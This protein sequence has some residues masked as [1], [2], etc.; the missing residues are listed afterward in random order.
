MIDFMLYRFRIGTFSNNKQKRNKSNYAG[1]CIPNLGSFNHFLYFAYIFI[2]IYIMSVTMAMLVD[3]NTMTFVIQIPR[4]TKFEQLHIFSSNVKLFAVLLS[5]FL[6]KRTI[7]GAAGGLDLLGICRYYHNYMSKKHYLFKKFLKSCEYVYIWIYALNFLLI[8]IINPSL[9]NPGPSNLSV[10]FQNLQGLIP[11]SQLGCTHPTL[12]STKIFEINS[13]LNN[14][15]P[16]IFIWN[17]TWLKRS[18]DDNEVVNTDKYKIFRLDR[19]N[20]T[21][22]PDPTSSRKFRSNG[23]G[24]MIGI[25]RELDVISAGINISCKAEILGVTLKFRNGKKVAIC[26]C[27]RVGTLGVANHNNIESYI[28][29]VL[30]R[31]GINN[32]VLIG[33]F[34]MAHTQWS[35]YQTNDNVERLFLDS[36][37]NFG[38]QQLVDS[39]THCKGNIL[40]L[41]LTNSPQLVSNI[42]VADEFL[43]CKSDHFPIQFKVKSYARKKKTAK[44]EIYN[45]KRANW[46]ALISELDS[47]NW[48]HLLSSSDVEVAWNAFK[49]HLFCVVDKH[50]PKIKIQNQFQPPW[51]DSETYELCREKE[52]LRSA[53]KRTKSDVNYVK[54]ANCRR[55]FKRLVQGK[56]RDNFKD[57]YNSNLITKKFWSYVKSK[58][59]SHRIPDLV[60][61]KD[62]YR[63]N[64]IDQAELFNKFF[65]DQFSEPSTYD[66]EIDQTNDIFNIDFRCTRIYNILH[67]LNVNKA[68]GPDGIHGKVLKHCAT[69]ISYPL[70][71]LFNLSYTTGKIP[72]EWKLANVVPVHKKGCKSNVE[73]YRPISL[74][75][76]V[77]KV[78]EKVI[79]DELMFRCGHL[80]D[81]RQHGFL[82]FRS[83]TT[84]MIG[85]CDS[86]ALSLNKNTRSDVIY[87]DF[88][89]AFDTV[90]H[91]LILRKLKFQYNI[92][93]KLLRFFINYLKNRKQCIVLSNTKSSVQPVISGV[94]QGSILGPT[95]F[96]LFLNDITSGLNDGTNICMYADDTKVWREINCEND[97]LILQNDI[98]YLLD[99]AHNNKMKFHPSK[100]KVLS[101]TRN[102]PPLLDILPNIQF[103]Y[104]LGS[105]IID[106]CDSEKDLGI[107]M[108]GSLNFNEHCEYLYSKANQK[109]AMLKRN[110]NFVNNARMKR[111]LYLTLVRSIFEHCPIVW[112][113]ASSSPVDKLESIQKRAFKWIFDDLTSSY[114]CMELYYAHCKQLNILP[115]KFRFDYHD[116]KMFHIIVNEYICVK[117]PAY[118]KPFSENRLRSSHLDYKC[119]VSDISPRNL[120]SYQ[121]SSTNRSNSAF[122][123]SFFY[124]THL[125]WNRLPLSL[126]ETTNINHFKSELKAHIWREFVSNNNS[127][128]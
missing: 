38:F 94:P 85:Y 93:G 122:G 33:D 106:Y 3:L 18:I 61:L 81:D 90:N 62:T 41:L 110:C 43:M 49:A 70:S 127:I 109:L 86:L 69:S 39:P 114:S 20:H 13:Y 101:I 21:H 7:V 120:N 64:P 75:C 56:M 126:R 73:N 24:V 27:Y 91:D 44:R 105:C 100:C 76:I 8:T 37:S 59:N 84:Q 12:D 52:R 31:R 26:T 77:M 2:M 23:G 79:R 28:Q 112:R 22:P 78:Y 19:S 128:G 74:T 14:C 16:D 80:I 87:F 88:Q 47:T 50:I 57:E 54:Y 68:M 58:S 82:Q 5:W 45:F 1:N 124:R 118:L 89:K 92:D 97:H 48:Q 63:T 55:S 83:C 115:I 111:S 103:V 17:E 46:D 104:S 121:N 51:F 42:S 29:G 123:N 108:N 36:F 40:D 125:L 6:I 65:K 102:P 32:M 9:L 30:S 116:L 71:I 34:N 11:F 119:Y 113:P 25:N 72:L 98:N 107:H 10:V 53:Y 66:I 117:I 99:W 60:N 4:L 35:S 67:K 96:V 15:K 95:L